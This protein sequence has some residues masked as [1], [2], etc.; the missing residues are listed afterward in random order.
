LD[1]YFQI[2]IFI[3]AYSLLGFSLSFLIKNLG[4]ISLSQAAF[5]GLGSYSSV[6]L[7]LKFNLSFFLTFPLA[8]IITSVVA[9]V[10]ISF[11][12]RIVDDYFM[13]CTMGLQLIITSLF[14]NT[15][16][17]TGGDNGIINIPNIKIFNF[18]LNNDLFYLSFFIILTILV[19]ILFEKLQ[20]SSIGKTMEV[21]KNDEILALSLGLDVNK[22][23][24]NA[25]VFS[26]VLAAA[27]GVFYAHFLKFLTPNLFT[28]D[29]SFFIL[30]VVIISG[31]DKNIYIILSSILLIS[32]PNI[33]NLIGIQ[34][35]VAAEINQI[36]YS[37]ILIII[38]FRGK[39]IK[40]FNSKLKYKNHIEQSNV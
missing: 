36:I 8:L 5:L 29:E 31:M 37:C 30:F 21:V 20:K 35:N 23:K 16:F 26:S 18:A 19:M 24:K 11:A 14:K 34:N 10:F 32:L 40:Y 7:S 15:T 9:F 33:L 3:L 2:L 22:I 17:L 13:L 28:L 6:I 4:M 39:N 38:I 27:V 12:V 1:Y 25:F